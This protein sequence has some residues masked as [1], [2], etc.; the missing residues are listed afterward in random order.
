[1]TAFKKCQMPDVIQTC[2]TRRRRL[3][4]ISVPNVSNPGRNHYAVLHEDDAGSNAATNGQEETARGSAATGRACGHRGILMEAPRRTKTAITYAPGAR[5]ATS[6]LGLET[7][8]A[9]QYIRRKSLCL[10]LKVATSSRKLPP[11]A[12]PPAT[13]RPQQHMTHGHCWILG[14]AGRQHSHPKLSGE[15][16]PTIAGVT[17][18]ALHLEVGPVQRHTSRRALRRRMRTTT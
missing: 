16:P 7:T 8:N 18:A 9:S 4:T 3:D 15:R 13:M 6:H 12:P 17:G 10:Q 11:R 5:A 1:M 14:A 2:V